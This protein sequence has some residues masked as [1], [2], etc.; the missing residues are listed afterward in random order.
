MNREELEAK[1]LEEICSCWFYDLTN[2]IEAL[3]SDELLKII[4][5]P[6]YCHIN[7]QI[8]NPVPITDFI[9]ELKNCSDYGHYV[10]KTLDNLQAV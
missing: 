9:E 2:D 6:L 8:Q 7:N 10:N 5:T 1:A 3:D 4:N